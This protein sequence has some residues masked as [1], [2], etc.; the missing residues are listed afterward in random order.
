MTV[1]YGNDKDEIKI[2]LILLILSGKGRIMNRLLG[3]VVVL[4]VGSLLFFTGCQLPQGCLDGKGFEQQGELEDAADAYESCL[5][6]LTGQARRKPVEQ[7]LARL[8]K[9]ITD[10]ALSDAK[11]L[12]GS[13]TT[14]AQLDAAIKKV[15]GKIKYDSG[16]LLAN[17]LTA[18]K[19]T[20]SQLEAQAKRLWKDSRKQLEAGQ[21]SKSINSI[22]QA[23]TINPDSRGMLD[24][25]ESIIAKRDAD[26]S[27]RIK[28]SCDAGKHA[29]ATALL[30]KLRA[31]QPLPANNVLKSMEIHVSQTL[32][33]MVRKQAEQ[34]RDEKKYYSAY[35]LITDSKVSKC[36]D[37]LRNVKR[38][39]SA[40][41]KNLAYKEKANV[42]AF[43][44]YIASVKAYALAP[45]DEEIF[46]LHRDCSDRIDELIQLKIAISTFDC[47]SSDPDAGMELS[48]QLSS[49]LRG[50]LPY[51]VTLDE[52]EKV[53][54]VIREKG[55]EQGVF[56]VGLDYAIF[57]NL[58]T[59]TIK[60]QLT[61]RDKS[62]KV[63][64]C[65]EEQPNPQ[66]ERMVFKYG[67]NTSVWPTHPPAT[68]TKVTNEFIK[69]KV[70]NKQLEGMIVVTPR[71]YSAK[72]NE[73]AASKTFSVTRSIEDRFQEEVAGTNITE[74][75]LEMPMSELQL[76]EALKNEIVKEMSQWIRQSFEPRQMYYYDKAEYFIERRQFSQAVEHLAKG[77]YYCLKDGVAQD[78]QWVSK[79]RQKVLFDLTE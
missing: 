70:G 37:L 62:V 59:L 49:C 7:D 64:T 2:M 67:L 44:A 4:F 30:A 75:L 27:D 35:V 5:S 60:S 55:L 46:D 29:E 9:K 71:L 21:W 19:K 15:S 18:Y 73:I 50:T 10:K 34:L 6:E 52:R 58:S 48:D 65:S 36:V 3:F 28:A 69:Y 26:Y 39:G 79:I 57:G 38:D 74:D 56:L 76:R 14:L 72:Q 33:R 13:G 23:I 22:R 40:F 12:I 25:Q 47:P 32:E 78:D 61:E 1:W 66:Y 53:E 8:K 24:L 54:F 20:R 51:G 42:N 41:Y 31:E 17:N 43:H 45:D 11:S 68:L 16:K 63:A 77:Y